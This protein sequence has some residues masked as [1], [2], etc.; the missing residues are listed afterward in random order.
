MKI[1]LMKVGARWCGPCQALAKRGTLEKFA[2]A[3]DDVRLEIHDDDTEGGSARWEAFAE[4]W[5]VRDMPTL[6]WVV[7]GEEV[8]RS[9]NVTL[10]EIEQ[11][12]KKVLA[13][14]GL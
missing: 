3:H 4:K 5:D 14:A 10:A 6:I 13:K 1:V 8:L 9:G 12:Y 7:Q 11:Q 2:A